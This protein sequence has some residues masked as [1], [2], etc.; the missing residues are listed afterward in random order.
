V[1][2]EQTRRTCAPDTGHAVFVMTNDAASNEVIAYDR[3]SYGTLQSPQHYRTNGRGAGGHGDPLSS[4]GSLHLSQDH[5]WL[6]A[7]NAGSGTL[8]IFRVDGAWLALI[9]EVPTSGAEPESIAQHGSLVYVL[10]AAGSSRV[11]GFFL[12]AGQLTPI[13]GSQQFLSS[14]LANP[15]SVA[16]TPDGRFLLVTEKAHNNVDVLAVRADGTLSAIKQIRASARSLRRERGAER[17]GGRLRDR[18]GRPDGGDL[19]LRHLAR[20]DAGG[21]QRQRADARCGELLERRHP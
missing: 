7:A 17:H 8:S 21:D 14:N 12:N 6:F 13:R 2:Q 5:Q 1:L 11:T 20:R 19:L 16:F 3:T 18:L 4:Q 10:T 15:A 9:D